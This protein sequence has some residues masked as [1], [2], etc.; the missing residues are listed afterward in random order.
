MSDKAFVIIKII[1]YLFTVCSQKVLDLVSCALHRHRYRLVETPQNVVVIGA[2]F[3]GYEAARVLANTLPTGYRTVIVERNTHFQFSWALP[4]FSVI[5]DYEHRAFI[6]YG[7]YLKG[8]PD[9]SYL[10]VRDSFTE[11]TK[12]SA[13]R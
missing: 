7:S 9:G 11:V 1:A 5:P 4:R 13:P 10:F 8:A 3:A 2:S 12:D 6:P